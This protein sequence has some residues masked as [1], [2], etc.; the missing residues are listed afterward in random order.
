M[1]FLTPI[2]SLTFLA[3]VEDVH[4]HLSFRRPKPNQAREHSLARTFMSDE[5]DAA[6]SGH[7][8]PAKVYLF[9][10]DAELDLRTGSFTITDIYWAPDISGRNRWT[11]EQLRGYLAH[12]DLSVNDLE[13]DTF[14][15]VGVWLAGY[16]CEVLKSAHQVPCGF[17]PYSD[18]AARFMGPPLLDDQESQG[19]I[20][21]GTN[22]I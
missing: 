10:K 17:E 18:D 11:E 1:Y 16:H 4:V 21:E 12:W 3:A 5:L 8:P 9:L 6:I 14:Y 20:T 22:H 19:K 15:E 2:S 7:I 13:L